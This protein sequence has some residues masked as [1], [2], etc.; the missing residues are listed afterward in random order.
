MGG[1]IHHEWKLCVHQGGG[2]F[3][4]SPDVQC[5][6]SLSIERARFVVVDDDDDDDDEGIGQSLSFFFK[7]LLLTD[8]GSPT[9]TSPPSLSPSLIPTLNSLRLGSAPTASH[10]P[11]QTVIAPFASCA[12]GRC[13]TC[14][15]VITTSTGCVHRKGLYRFRLQVGAMNLNAPWYT[16]VLNCCKVKTFTLRVLLGCSA[17]F[18][19]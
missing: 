8:H 12:R 19:F 11:P 3:R 7:L 18:L 13:G 15:I 9:I 5:C 4:A 10:H 17:S 16:F 1:G 6:F 14:D 2:C